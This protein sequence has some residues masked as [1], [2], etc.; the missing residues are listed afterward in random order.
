MPILRPAVNPQ[1]WWDVQRH[2][3]AAGFRYGDGLD[4]AYAIICAESNKDAGVTGPQRGAFTVGNDDGSYDRG[5]AQLNSKGHAEVSDPEA[6]DPAEACRAMRRIY[7][8]N[9]KSFD[10]WA[11]YGRGAPDAPFWQHIP[12]AQKAR[13]AY[14]YAK[15]LGL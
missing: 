3:R 9:G 10:Q 1:S 2:L 11:A 5:L 13:K 6:Y 4:I 15:G 12:E 8:E 7:L 14:D